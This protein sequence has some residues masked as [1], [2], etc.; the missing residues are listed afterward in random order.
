MGHEIMG[1]SS[2]PNAAEDEGSPRRRPAR[3]SP[4]KSAGSTRRIGPPRP[5]EPGSVGGG[6]KGHQFGGLKG[7]TWVV[8]QWSPSTSP[9]PPDSSFVFLPSPCVAF[10][11][12]R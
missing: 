5:V 9:P 8:T 10:G 1:W 12:P 2:N 3:L 7:T 6:E 4:G 11:Y